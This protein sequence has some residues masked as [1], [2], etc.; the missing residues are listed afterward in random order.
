[1]MERYLWSP[2][3]TQFTGD[4]P[5]TRCLFILEQCGHR[6][7]GERHD[8]QYRFRVVLDP[9]GGCPICHSPIQGRY[10]Y[11]YYTDQA[12]DPGDPDPA[13]AP[14]GII[15]REDLRAASAETQASPPRRS[16][17]Q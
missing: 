3:I 10:R 17:G 1:M 14:H 11:E 6:L 4:P 12:Y 7:E 5:F 2:V 16:R 13:V 9:D 15:S 8:T